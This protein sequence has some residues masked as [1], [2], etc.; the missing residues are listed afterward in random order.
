MKERTR[1][2]TYQGYKYIE[3]GICAAQG[4]KANGLNCGLNSDKNKNDLCLL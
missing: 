2:K 3:G 4:F 1:M